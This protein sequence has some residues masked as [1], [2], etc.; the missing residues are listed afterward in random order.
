MTRSNILIAAFAVAAAL[1]PA[2]AVATGCNHDQARMSCAE[3]QTWDD[4]TGRC[5][6][7][8]S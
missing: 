3:G 6:K 4:A 8:T 2:L 7:T 1:M 5:V